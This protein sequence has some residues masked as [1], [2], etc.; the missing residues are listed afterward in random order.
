MSAVEKNLR[1]DG[2]GIDL[3]LGWVLG[4]KF[5]I[6]DGRRI[7]RGSKRWKRE[8]ARKNNCDK[9]A[10]HPPRLR[11]GETD[12]NNEFWVGK[13]RHKHAFASFGDNDCRPIRIGADARGSGAITL[14]TNGA[15]GM[16]TVAEDQDPSLAWSD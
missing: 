2:D 7:K 12:D 11:F 15:I 10:F 14:A 6:I 4:A 16:A 3:V 1:L 5:S 13:F 9:Q 8:P